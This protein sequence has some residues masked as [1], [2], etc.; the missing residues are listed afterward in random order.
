MKKI[1]TIL[2]ILFATLFLVS[3]I[4][5]EENLIGI[6]IDWT[7]QETYFL[8][9]IVNLEEL[10]INVLAQFETQTVTL[11]LDNEE[12]SIYGSGVI[13][14]DQG[15]ILLNTSELGTFT[16]TFAYKG[17]ITTVTFTT[18]ISPEAVSASVALVET[19][20][21]TMQTQ[22]G[23]DDGKEN[24]TWATLY[25]LVQQ[26]DSATALVNQLET[27]ALKTDLLTRLN[28]VTALFQSVTALDMSNK[29]IPVNN[30]SLLRVFVNLQTLNISNIGIH[31][32]WAFPNLPNLQ[33][34]VA[35]GNE[36]PDLNLLPILP[37]LKYLDVSDNNIIDVNGLRIGLTPK[38]QN[39]E[40]FIVSNNLIT[41]FEGMR[42]QT[43]LHTLIASNANR[44]QAGNFDSLFCI[45][46]STIT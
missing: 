34:L 6:S 8:D 31:D 36:V 33:T 27:G 13:I 30:L 21:T 25:S 7:P 20:A 39:L 11:S 35:V 19:L 9:E 12:I 37:S 38:F 22:L 1:L 4:E 46:K 17:K 43:K 24:L 41:D 45:C 5:L 32:F 42:S 10:N 18:V 29:T 44:L 40:T 28:V 15:N 26:Y 2:T 23:Q 14:D 3:C 16:V